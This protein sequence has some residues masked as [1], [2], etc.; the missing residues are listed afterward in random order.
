ML[1]AAEGAEQTLEAL[2]AGRIVLEARGQ[3]WT[4]AESADDTWL[5]SR[6]NC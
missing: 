4:S 6:P 5:S 3:R 1:T 2:R